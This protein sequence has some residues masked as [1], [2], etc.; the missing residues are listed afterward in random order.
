MIQITK[1]Y[2]RNCQTW[3]LK[4][5]K[6]EFDIPLSRQLNLWNSMLCIKLKFDS[7]LIFLKTKCFLSL[8]EIGDPSYA[9][10][11]TIAKMNY[12]AKKETREHSFSMKKNKLSL[13]SLASHISEPVKST[14]RWVKLIKLHL[15]KS[16]LQ[17]VLPSRARIEARVPC[18]DKKFFSDFDWQFSMVFLHM[19][20]SSASS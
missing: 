17:L 1:Y 15:N 2:I 20:F 5:S 18:F 6:R 8:T 11:I 19:Y 12:Q 3:K 10:T 9:S 4:D 13:R 16:R 14:Q 7:K